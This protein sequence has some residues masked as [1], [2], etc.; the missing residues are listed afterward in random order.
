MSELVVGE[1]VVL[2]LRLAKLA[3]RALALGLDVAVQVVLLLLGTFVVAGVAGG[4]DES[5]AAALTLVFVVGVWLGYPVTFETLTRGRS[6]GKL[7]M[8]L[9][10][11]R[12]D[13]GPIRFRH[14]FVRGLMGIVELWLS[15]GTI[16]LIT[17]LASSRGKRLGDYLAGTVVIRE[18]VPRQGAPVTPMPPALAAWAAGLDL[19]RLPDDLALAARQ[20]LAR[21]RELSPEVR[22]AMGIRLADAVARVTTPVPPPGVP[23]WAYLAAVVAERTRRETARLLPPMAAPPPWLA[24]APW[25]APTQAP[26][27][28]R[29]WPAPAAPVASPPPAPAPAPLQERA[30]GPFAPPG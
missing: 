16:A 24:A 11:V 28:A 17:S 15:S 4:S 21:G 26:A 2:E 6:L 13:G 12:E 1:A 8:G 30:A 5:L 7:A 27:A 3:S 19:S 23:A 20:Y 10:V 18:R 14:A 22:D 9:R 25:P 29:P